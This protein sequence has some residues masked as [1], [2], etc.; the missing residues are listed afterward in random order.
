MD[1]KEKFD[2]VV[3]NFLNVANAADVRVYELLEQ[4]FKLFD[5]VELFDTRQHNW[6]NISEVI[7]SR[8]APKSNL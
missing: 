8:L 6:H 5:G 7:N 4:K 2:V 1:G 3:V